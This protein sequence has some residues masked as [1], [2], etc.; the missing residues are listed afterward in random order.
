M[1]R[2]HRIFA[3][4]GVL[5]SFWMTMVVP[6]A[7]GPRPESLPRRQKAWRPDLKDRAANRRRF[8]SPRRVEAIRAKH[9]RMPHS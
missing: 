8:R 1:D 4:F 9:G 3:S 2:L 6:P 5:E 7:Y